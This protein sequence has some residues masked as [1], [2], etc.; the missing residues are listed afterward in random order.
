LRTPEANR[1]RQRCLECEF[2][3]DG[4]FCP[5]HLKNQ[6]TSFVFAT[7]HDLRQHMAGPTH[8]PKFVLVQFANDMA[9]TDDNSY[10]C[11]VEGC[12]HHDGTITAFLKHLEQQHGEVYRSVLSKHD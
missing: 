7:E 1:D 6:T 4:D 8:D 10:C 3:F 12:G 9:R 11:P 5:S 2:S